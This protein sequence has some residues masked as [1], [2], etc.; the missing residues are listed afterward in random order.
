MQT[1]H[2]SIEQT[3]ALI[4]ETAVPGT[5]TQV[6]L[7][8]SKARVA[9]QVIARVMLAAIVIQVFFAGLGVFQVMNFMPHIVFGT[10]VVLAGLSLPIVAWRGHLGRVLV[11]S[12]LAL[13]LLLILQG[14]LIDVGHLAPVVAALHPVNA[15][16]VT[17]LAYNLAFPHHDQ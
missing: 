14:V 3:G 11:R 9:H 7:P 10:A 1:S 4:A 13:T 16:I 12:S 8:R 5:S 17:L 2:P 6:T 15:M